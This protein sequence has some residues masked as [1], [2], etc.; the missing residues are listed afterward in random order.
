MRR[1][2][3][4]YQWYEKDDLQSLQDY[5]KA[6]IDFIIEHVLEYEDLF[7]GTNLQVV[8]TSPESMDVSITA[9]K[10]LVGFHIA[11]LDTAET[12]TIDA[13][14]TGSTRYDI[15]SCTVAEANDT[16][17]TKNVI[18]PVTEVITSTTLVCSA[19]YRFTIVYNKNTSSVPVGEV[20]L[21][22]ITV[23]DGVTE[24]YDTD[25]EDIRPVKAS[26][27]L[28]AHA[29][30]DP[31]DHADGSI[32]DVAI[33]STADIGLE[34]CNGISVDRLDR[35]IGMGMPL[36]FSIDITYTDGLPTSLTQTGDWS[37]NTAITYDA[38]DNVT[39][40]V[41]EDAAYESTVT[42]TYTGDDVTNITG[43]VVAK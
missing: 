10:A 11:E 4:D 30:S 2:L 33:S 14:A 39:T 13:N 7:T 22:K 38:N 3:N 24:I 35:L 16:A 37:V 27:D 43:A 5:C 15:I 26:A 20:G 41:V 25:I 40:V 1:I 32:G 31:I 6:D 34:K 18:D 36:N 28:A 42:L 21:A 17:I 23:Y 19:A 9:G 29:A 12:Q 8:A